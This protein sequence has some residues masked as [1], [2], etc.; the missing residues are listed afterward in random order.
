MK[1]LILTNLYP[2]NVFGGYERLCYEVACALTARGHDVTVLTSSYGKSS[3]ENYGHRVIRE[4][5]LFATEGNLYKPFDFAQIQGQGHEARN[6]EIFNS[7]VNEIKPDILF[8]WNLY[9][10]DRGLLE[11]I[12]GCA[13]DKT[14]LLT[15][16]WMIAQLNS[17]FIG[18]YF[19]DKVF[20]GVQ[21]RYGIKP[22]IR[23]FAKQLG[24]VYSRNKFDINGR[25]IFPSRFMKRLYE[26][27]GFRF[28]KGDSIC[29]HG[30]NF[31]HPPNPS[32]IQRLDLINP[33]EVRLLFAG[34]I[35]KVKG[36]HT[37]IEAIREIHA[38]RD[39]LR[40]ILTIVGDT[41]DQEY[42]GEIRKLA[43]SPGVRDH[44]IFRPTVAED[45]LFDLFQ[46]HDI[47][48]FPSLYEPFSLTLIHAL[49][50]GIPTVASDAGGNVEI[51]H[52]GKTG[53]VF[54]A[55]N[56]KDLAG[57]VL[58][59]V[60]DGKL[61]TSLSRSAVLR[62]EEFTFDNMVSRIEK[63][64]EATCYSAGRATTVKG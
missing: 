23:K 51:V 10:F 5:F 3:E 61:R 57:K 25:A 36:V 41:E 13:L 17:Q 52:D 48:L 6:Q 38:R 56:Y 54:G 33:A 31:L 2:P 1:I 37:A 26:D 8:V 49:E 4:L 12:D 45:E 14:Y 22:A 27:A 18:A 21:Q 9:F 43:D 20:G 50:S 58:K 46:Q 59:L 34:R 64:L 15:D 39:D 16:N 53:L 32:R 40:V 24:R 42:L 63:D 30:V 7:T 11:E 28:G 55:G 19:S 29:Y 47:Y 60:S 44:V 35:V 62:A